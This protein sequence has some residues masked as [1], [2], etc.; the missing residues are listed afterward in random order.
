[1]QKDKIHRI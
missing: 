1:M